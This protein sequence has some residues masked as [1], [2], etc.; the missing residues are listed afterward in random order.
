MA[1]LTPFSGKSHREPEGVD[2][3]TGDRKPMAEDALHR[4]LMIY[5]I[6][7][8]KLHFADRPD[9]Y[10]SGNDFLYYE[11]G[12]PSRRISPD[13]YVVIGVE[14]KQRRRFYKVWEEN[15]VL[16]AV[17]FEFTSA[18]T[19]RE[20]EGSKRTIYETVLRVP[21]YFQFDPS[22]DYLKPRLQGK[23]LQNDQYVTIALQNDR[24]YSEQLRLDLVIVEESL[25]FYDPVRGEWLHT[26]EE[27]AQRAEAA[28]AELA[29]LRAE[30]EALR[31][32][33]E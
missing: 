15:N 14:P 19:R 6:P 27:Q 32:K 11:E 10:I 26:H 33:E 25:R 4:D 22:G 30:L 23:R 21:E 17:V 1:T 5:A 29:R 24:M 2:Y 3:P 31:S 8:L 28:E 13:C 9:V 16:P 7:A 12:V 18:K 20:D